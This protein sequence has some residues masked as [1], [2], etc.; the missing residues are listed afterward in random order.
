MYKTLKKKIYN[1]KTRKN[2]KFLR[3]STVKR[4]KIGGS[5]ITKKPKSGPPSGSVVKIMSEFEKKTDEEKKQ[6]TG[7]IQV[8]IYQA[9][10]VVKRQPIFKTKFKLNRDNDGTYYITHTDHIVNNFYKVRPHIHYK[11][12]AFCGFPAGG[13][14]RFAGGQFTTY[15]TAVDN[16][17]GWTHNILHEHYDLNIRKDWLELIKVMQKNIF[18]QMMT[19]FYNKSNDDMIQKIKIIKKLNLQ[20]EVEQIKTLYNQARDEVVRILDLLKDKSVRAYYILNEIVNKSYANTKK[21]PNEEITKYNLCKFTLDKLIELNFSNSKLVGK[22]EV[23]N[24]DITEKHNN[25]QNALYQLQYIKDNI[26][27]TKHFDDTDKNDAIILIFLRK[28]CGDRNKYNYYN[29]SEAIPE[30]IENLFTELETEKIH[31]KIDEVVFPDSKLELPAIERQISFENRL[32]KTINDDNTNVDEI[33]YNFQRGISED[34]K[35]ETS[36]DSKDED[37]FNQLQ[38]KLTND[39]ENAESKVNEKLIQLSVPKQNS[40]KNKI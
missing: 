1:S 30:Y 33:V 23:V 18:D 10:D 31:E 25:I 29:N 7:V 36:L 16:L 26:N 13:E 32:S 24:I 39:Y 34:I 6:I 11:E 22:N 28:W 14:N 27:D 20:Q 12:N 21:K 35:K 37:I 4:N 38:S 17:S 9:L 15:K 5:R 19:D 3:R 2:R 8:S 40:K